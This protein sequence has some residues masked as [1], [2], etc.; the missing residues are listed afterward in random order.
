MTR[1][2]F[3]PVWFFIG[4]EINQSIKNSSCNGAAGIERVDRK[5]LSV[6]RLLH[7]LTSA[8][9]SNPK[10]SATRVPRSGSAL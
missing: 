7:F 9:T 5:K 2:E 6:I 4:R 10:P 1:L 8:G 3:F